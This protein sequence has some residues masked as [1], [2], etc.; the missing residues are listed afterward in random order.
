[1]IVTSEMVFLSYA[2]EDEKSALQ[3]YHELKDAGIIIWLDKESIQPGAEWKFAI[4]NAIKKCRFFIA[5]LSTKSVSKKG[6]VQ[7]ELRQ[8]IEILDEF[9]QNE[10]Y[11][12]PVRLDSCEAPHDRLNDFQWVDLFPKWDEGKNKLLR[13]FGVMDDETKLKIRENLAKSTAG[14][15]APSVRIDG[16]YQSKRIS[17]IYSYIRFYGNGLVIDVYSIGSANAIVKWFDESHELVS[18]G[19]YFISGNKIKFSS[20]DSNGTV[21]FE[22]EIQGENLLFRTHSHITQERSVYEYKFIHFD[23]ITPKEITL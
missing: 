18:K 15:F 14:S 4:K 13:F 16:I 21:D 20:T 8:A 19:T 5:L 10:T 6:F 9:P 2:R 17:N 23:F 1:M 3:L 7:S 22:G 12:I 11:L